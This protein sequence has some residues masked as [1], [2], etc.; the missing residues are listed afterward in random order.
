MTQE[1][2]VLVDSTVV[3]YARGEPGTTRDRCRAYLEHV[4]EGRGRAYASVEMVQEVVFHGR[5][6]LGGD[7]RAAVAEVR[8]LIPAF[9]LLDFDR[10]ILDLAL[11]LMEHT[12]VRGRD[13]V[14]SATALTYGIPAIASPDPVFDTVPGL[15]RVDPT[16][17]GGD[18]RALDEPP[19]RS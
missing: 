5:R 4:W 18:E 15:R 8:E 13:A 1:N 17:S 9:I 6:R 19:G 16:T 11:D 10:E 3:I 12:A 2:A 7:G 14:H